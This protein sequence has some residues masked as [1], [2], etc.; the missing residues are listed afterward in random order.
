MAN[1]L[2]MPII[3]NTKTQVQKLTRP[4]NKNQNNNSQIGHQAARSPEM[5][6][7]AGGGEV[8]ARSRRRSREASGRDGKGLVF[9]VKGCSGGGVCVLTE[10]CPVKGRD[11]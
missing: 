8:R 7:A 10:P 9:R 4:N 2:R 1:S 5:G 6:G 3:S 11:P